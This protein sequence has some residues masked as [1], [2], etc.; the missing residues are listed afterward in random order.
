M[1]R[2][3]RA[4]AVVLEQPLQAARQ[5][6]VRRGAARRWRLPVGGAR[7]AARAVAR[8][9]PAAVAA[10]AAARRERGRRAGDAAATGGRRGGGVARAARLSAGGGAAVPPS[11]GA[12]RRERRLVRPRG[13]GGG[14]A[15]G[16]RVAAPHRLRR[17]AGQHAHVHRPARARRRGAEDRRAR[18]HAAP[19]LHRGDRRAEWQRWRPPPLP[20]RVLAAAARRGAR[21][22]W[23][24][25]R[26]AF[27]RRAASGPPRA[28]QRSA[29]GGRAESPGA[30][31]TVGGQCGGR[32]RRAMDAGGVDP[33]GARRGVCWNDGRGAAAG[34][35]AGG[36]GD[37]AAARPRLAPRGARRAGLPAA[38]AG[39]HRR[40]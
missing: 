4:A 21:L 1:A 39:E 27:E 20:P 28:A 7:R 14:A 29:R 11:R 9:K 37:V 32:A 40:G 38:V 8:A 13:G 2:A 5:E 36:R 31:P 6:P 18:V 22:P 15:R 34:A 35:P 25:G 33:G 30:R 17:R 23:P 16:A 10:D 26:H 24:A 19:P 3:V 12:A